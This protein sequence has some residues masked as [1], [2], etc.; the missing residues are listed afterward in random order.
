M[1][2]RGEIPNERIPRPRNAVEAEDLD[3]AWIASMEGNWGDPEKF[4]AYLNDPK[5][6]P[7]GPEVNW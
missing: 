7:R 3:Y 4:Q 5:Y 1:D 6:F 2:A